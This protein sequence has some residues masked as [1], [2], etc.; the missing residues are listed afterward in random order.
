ME[1]LKK[2]TILSQ[3]NQFLDGNPK[4]EPGVLHLTPEGENRSSFRNV[5]CPSF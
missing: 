2:P 1:L 4:P 3:D 5:V